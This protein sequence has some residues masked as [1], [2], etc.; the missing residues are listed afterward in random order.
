MKLTENQLENLLLKA[1][2]Q[3]DKTKDTCKVTIS[4]CLQ[5]KDNFNKNILQSCMETV[6]TTDLCKLFIINRS[7]NIRS[8]LALTI[9]VIKTNINECRKIKNNINCKN[10]IELCD[11]ILTETYKTLKKLYDSI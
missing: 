8:C 11:K 2:D 9:N 5:I 10:I 3:L 1:F 6:D 7:P 4:Q